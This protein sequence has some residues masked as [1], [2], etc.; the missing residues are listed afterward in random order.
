MRRLIFALS[1]ALLANI[2]IAQ[3][4]LTVD[5][6]K[7]IRPVTHCA[8]GSLYGFTETLPTDVATMVAPLK[9][10]VFANPAISGTGH[11]QPIGDALKVSARLVG[12]TAK[13]QVRLAD[14]LPGWP[15]KWPGLTSWLN[16]CTSIINAKK[17]SGRTN[18]D[19]YEIW[20]EPYGTWND[21]NGS[22]HSALW[23]PTY[24]LIKKLDPTERIIG[25]SLAYYSSSQMKDFL[26]YCKANNCLPDVI[27]WHQW[28]AAGFV[29]ALNNYRALEVS[30]GISPRAVSINEYSSKTSDPYEGCPGYSV[31]FIAKFERHG[32]ESACI[33]WWHTAYPGRLG[34]LL[35]PSN[36]KGGGWYLYKWYGDMSGNMVQVTPPND[37]SDG[38]DGFGCIDK[39]LNY[40]SI[41]IGGNYTG[42]VNVKIN[43]IPATYGSKVKVTLDYVTWVNKDSPVSG[44][45]AI[46]STSYNVSNNTITVPVNVSSNLYAYRVLVE[47]ENVVVAPTIK[48]TTPVNNAVFTAPATIPIDVTAADADGTISNIFY[49]VNDVLVQEEWVAPYA[50]NYTA[51]NAGTYIIKAIATDNS[52]NKAEDIVTVKVNVPQGPYGG[53]P[54]AIPGKIELENF[55]VGGNAVAYSD[56]TPGSQVDPRPNFR[57]DEDV[58]IENCTDVGTGYN[59]GWTVAGEWLEYTVNV[60]TAGKYT[61]TFRAACNGDGRTVSLSTNGTTI[62]NT[63]AIPNTTGW[64]IWEDVTVSDVNLEAG[65]QTLRLTIGATDYVNLNYM[66]FTSQSLPPTT[67]SLK[68]GW[69][70]IG[71]PIDGSTDIAKAL[72]SIWDKVEVVKNNDAFYNKS[73]SGFL[74]SLTK[75]NWSGGYLVKVSS[76]C[77]LDWIVR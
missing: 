37:K 31:P 40:A 71:C 17:A 24:D 56:N 12:T 5:L 18:Y 55:D 63:I 11:Q 76:N 8:S 67:I 20:N 13:V 3:Q 47:P 53:T 38:I 39:T 14:I 15:Y 49:Y 70:L 25:P 16:Q 26:T 27:C 4:T 21:A 68:T 44:T 7:E 46:S 45:T 60:A 73:Q 43:G 62:A 28:G 34:S 54:H 41:C 65:V 59:L 58:D 77:E 51:T 10:K 1:L 9:P 69:N 66:S 19:G 64:Q 57:T 22:F 2:A 36:Q 32:V 72:S 42:T 23:K 30:L 29:D 74:N 48:I 6:S 52:G 35:T 75:L 50:F 33:S 61:L